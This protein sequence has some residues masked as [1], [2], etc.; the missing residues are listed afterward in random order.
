MWFLLT[1]L[2]AVAAEPETVLVLFAEKPTGATFTVDGAPAP[3]THGTVS[4]VTVSAG[5]HQVVASKS[6]KSLGSAAVTVQAG[7][8]V[9]CKWVGAELDCYKDVDLAVVEVA[10]T[11]QASQGS[12]GMS[13]MSMGSLG[14]GGSYGHHGR[15]G[16]MGGSLSSVPVAVITPGS[17]G[18]GPA[19]LDLTVKSLDGSAAD[20]WVDGGFAVELREAV[21]VVRLP[22]GTH[23]LAFCPA[24]LTG[25]CAQGVLS[26]VDRPLVTMTFENGQAPRALDGVNWVVGENTPAPE[27]SPATEEPLAQPVP[28]TDPG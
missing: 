2:L 10:A 1:G 22:R 28:A 13:L 19:D 20:L 9:R 3:A 25:P 11:A 26:P 15:H 21:T 16:H 18:A 23:T 12:A 5:E 24:G 14:L 7:H 27:A 8:E 17:L 4:R 6:G